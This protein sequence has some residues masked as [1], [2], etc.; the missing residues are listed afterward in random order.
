VKLIRI[1]GYV[2]GSPCRHE[3]RYV[4]YYDPNGSG[5]D[6]RM[7][8]LRFD[9]RTTDDPAEAQR[10]VDTAQAH[11]AWSERSK[12]QP[13]RPWDGKPNRPLTGFSVEI[14]DAD[15]AG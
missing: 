9:L 5:R 13:Y 2:D 4:A 12:K 10:Y 3:G 11:R 14:I 6:E 7:G 15:D 1:L 8:P